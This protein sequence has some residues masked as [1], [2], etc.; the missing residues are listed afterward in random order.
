MPAG[1]R[2]RLRLGRPGPHRHQLPRHRRG[3]QVHG[4]PARPERRSRPRSVGR[5]AD[6]GHRRPQARR[7]RRGPGRRSSSGTSRDLQ[8]GQKVVAIGNPFGF[9]HTVTKGIVS[10][11]G[12][13][14]ARRRQRH[15]PGHDPDRRVDQ[16]RQLGR[17]AARLE[18]RAHRHEHDDLQPVGGL[19][20][21]SASPCP[22]TRSRRSCP[23][24]SS[25]GRSS[26]PTSAASR[27]SG[28]RWPGGP[29]S[30]GRSSSRST[31]DSRAYDLGLRG[32]TRD[33]FGRLLIRDVITAID[34]MKIKSWDDLF[35]A[36][37]GYKIGDTRDADGRARGQVAQG[38]DPARR[39]TRT[40]APAMR[41]SSPTS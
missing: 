30:R 31:R 11:L 1:Q 17:A 2:L 27:S 19:E 15:H 10:A 3:R 20:R 29:G 41:L 7:A 35:T 39:S 40:D 36:L 6:Q 23:R 32:L 16:P 12:R 34:A 22:S 18:R 13:I 21:A 9:D 38:R 25:S 5:D 28:T 26:G 14:D 8:V 33:N 4:Q 24:S 37:D